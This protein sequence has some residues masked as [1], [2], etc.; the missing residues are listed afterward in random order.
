MHSADKNKNKY[1]FQGE[2][3]EWVHD[4]AAYSQTFSGE[5]AE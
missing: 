5:S 3:I 4:H 2:K 1:K